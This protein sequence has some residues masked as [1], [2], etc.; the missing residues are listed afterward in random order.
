MNSQAFQLH[1]SPLFTALA[2]HPA[3]PPKHFDISRSTS[4]LNSTSTLE[5]IFI[6]ATK[7][8][9]L[10]SLLL[11]MGIAQ[12]PVS[13]ETQT[14]DTTSTVPA[15][16]AT[17]TDPPL[18][19]EDWECEFSPEDLTKH[20]E[21]ASRIQQMPLQVILACSLV[22]N[23]GL[24]GCEPLREMEEL[25]QQKCSNKP[26]YHTLENTFG[27]LNSDSSGSWTRQSADYAALDDTDPQDRI[28]CELSPDELKTYAELLDE[29]ARRPPT[30]NCISGKTI[31][32]TPECKGVREFAEFLVP[33]CFR[34]FDDVPSHTLENVN[35]DGGGFWI[36]EPNTDKCNLS[37]QE[38]A[39]LK[40]LVSRVLQQ[41]SIP[42][43]D[44]CACRSLISDWP[45]LINPD[46]PKCEVVQELLD[47]QLQ[48][49]PD[50]YGD[51][52][53]TCADL[54]EEPRR[55]I[56]CPETRDCQ[57]LWQHLKQNGL[58]Y[59]DDNDVNDTSCAFASPDEGE[60]L[61]RQRNTDTGEFR[62]VHGENKKQRDAD[63][64]YHPALKPIY[65]D[66]DV[67]EAPAEHTRCVLAELQRAL[68]E[69]EPWIRECQYLESALPDESSSK[70]NTIDNDLL[71]E[72][73]DADG[74]VPVADDDVFRRPQVTAAVQPTETAGLFDWF[75]LLDLEPFFEECEHADGY[76]AVED[77]VYEKMRDDVCSNP[78]DKLCQVPLPTFN[79]KLD[80]P[81]LHQDH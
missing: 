28:K 65:D 72:I 25:L 18:P 26:P 22:P 69:K 17:S 77:C 62:S 55:C 15:G 73:L 78:G 3:H 20:N 61:V 38:R 53:S 57:A 32:Q 9:L 46:R 51:M 71:D 80:V 58:Q 44:D 75:P 41:M 66:C 33:K 45:D 60:S 11:G 12:H 36:V 68:C 76:M 50:Y 1:T 10:S 43:H 16:F 4:I 74:V 47:F 19:P 40:E 2:A 67:L 6:M 52:I 30:K 42:H 59:W 24:P 13:E 64:P 56:S 29:L 70:F 31:S 7:S 5:R 14:R 54:Q 49:C 35:T 81:V 23:K 21:L 39:K 8:L 48:K 63:E 37:P 27:H 34:R 79:T